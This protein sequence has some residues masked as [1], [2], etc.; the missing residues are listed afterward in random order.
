MEAIDGFKLDYIKKSD[1]SYKFYFKKTNRSGQE[2]KKIVE[3]KFDDFEL[4]E[5]IENK[6]KNLLL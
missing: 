3:Y 6:I 2:A 5:F 4:D 1:N